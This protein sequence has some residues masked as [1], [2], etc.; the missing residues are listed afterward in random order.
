MVIQEEIHFF[1]L[2]YLKGWCMKC[3]ADDTAACEHSYS[4]ISQCKHKG[5]VRRK[6]NLHM[7]SLQMAK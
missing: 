4:M 7:G 6:P 1:L 5:G 2:M 3:H